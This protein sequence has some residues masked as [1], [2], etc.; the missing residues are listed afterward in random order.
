MA[1]VGL[2]H[3]GGGCLGATGGAAAIYTVASLILMVSV[4]FPRLSSFP[5][6]YL[7]WGSVLFVAYELCLSLSIGYAHTGRQ[8]I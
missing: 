3:G 8:A 6:R 1:H 7:V 4:G 2:L 5:R